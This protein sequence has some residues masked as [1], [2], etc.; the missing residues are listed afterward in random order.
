MKHFNTYKCLIDSDW[1][2]STQKIIEIKANTESNARKQIH[3]KY[4]NDCII[5]SITLIK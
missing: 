3:K 2:A 5:L 1:N 4:G